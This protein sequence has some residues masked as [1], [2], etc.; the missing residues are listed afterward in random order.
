METG[1]LTFLEAGNPRSGT[2]RAA[3]S[4]G[5]SPGVYSALFSPC[6]HVVVILCTSVS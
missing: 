5:P 6:P 3:L 1:S 2:G 4:R